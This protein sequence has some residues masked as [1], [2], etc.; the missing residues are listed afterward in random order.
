VSLVGDG[1]DYPPG[2]P[3]C[4]IDPMI[5]DF[6]SLPINQVSAYEIFEISDVGNAPLTVTI[7]NAQQAGSFGVNRPDAGDPTS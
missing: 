3:R 5:H 6:G 7:F 4:G 1:A 2:T